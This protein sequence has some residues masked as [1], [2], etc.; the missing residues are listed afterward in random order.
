MQMKTLFFFLCYRLCLFIFPALLF[1]LIFRI[2]FAK[3]E[4]FTEE[5]I[6]LYIDDIPQTNQFNC[7]QQQ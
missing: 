5:N 6:L 7:A 2:F 4:K 1:L 3:T